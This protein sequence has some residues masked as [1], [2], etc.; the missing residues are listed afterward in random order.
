[1]AIESYP[2][3]F[4][5]GDGRSAYYVRRDNRIIVSRSDC[6]PIGITVKKD[7]LE[8]QGDPIH[9]WSY[10]VEEWTGTFEPCM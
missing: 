6:L 8:T 3:V 2:I 5:C 1:M 9:A 10:V 7:T 4:Y